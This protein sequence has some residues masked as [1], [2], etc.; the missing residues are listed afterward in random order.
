MKRGLPQHITSSWSTSWPSGRI[1]SSIVHDPCDLRRAATAPCPYTHCRFHG[2]D[3]L[4]AVA[5]F[6]A[7]ARVQQK[8]DYIET[9]VACSAFQGCPDRTDAPPGVH[10]CAVGNETAYE[11]NVASLSSQLERSRFIRPLG[12][13]LWF[14]RSLRREQGVLLPEP[15]CCSQWLPS[16]P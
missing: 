7:S 1:S 13:P 4:N 2:D 3:V 10:I 16:E 14:V 11:A 8:L 15:S 9:P 6:R 12:R 5:A